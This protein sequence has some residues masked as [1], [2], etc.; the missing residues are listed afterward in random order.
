MLKLEVKLKTEQ[1]NAV[2]IFATGVPQGSPLGA[3]LFTLLLSQDT[4]SGVLITSRMSL[5]ICIL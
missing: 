2:P 5:L 1:K 4:F 3:S